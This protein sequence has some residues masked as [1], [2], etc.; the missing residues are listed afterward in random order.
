MIRDRASEWLGIPKKY[1]WVHCYEHGDEMW[2][3]VMSYLSLG[4]APT[5]GMREMLIYLSEITNGHVQISAG[6][7]AE[8]TNE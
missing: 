8:I 1:L 5:S 2:V 7:V 4:D 3:A 6:C